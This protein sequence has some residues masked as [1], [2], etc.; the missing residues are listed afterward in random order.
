MAAVADQVESAL[1]PLPADGVEALEYAALIQLGD[2]GDDVPGGLA[3]GGEDALAAFGVGVHQAEAS[4]EGEGLHQVTE[5]L[6]LL[7]AEDQALF[8]VLLQQVF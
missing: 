5:E 2:D 6:E 3:E 1:L 8:G 4:G 7:D